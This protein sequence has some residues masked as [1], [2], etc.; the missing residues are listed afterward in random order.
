MSY[1]VAIKYAVGSPDS[2]AG[3]RGMKTFHVNTSLKRGK[4][5]TKLITSRAVKVVKDAVKV[6]D[7]SLI[8]IETLK[9][10]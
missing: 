8:T 7:P 5:L 4:S 9:I 2:P 3:V 1:E 6:T 10:Y